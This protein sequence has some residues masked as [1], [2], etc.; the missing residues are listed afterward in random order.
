M[1]LRNLLA[2]A[3]AIAALGACNKKSND[4]PA[5]TA[6]NSTVKITMANPP[7]GGTWNDVVNETSDGYLMGNPNAKVKLVEIGSLGCP[8]C[9]KF[10]DEGVPHVLDLVKTGNLSWEFR[11]YLI[12]GPIDMAAD[13]IARCNGPKTFFPIA[14]AMYK[15]QENWMGKVEAAPEGQL[16]QMQNLPTD[17]IF[18]AYAKLAGLQDWAAARGI[19]Q[20]K[21][22]QCLSNQKMID[23][24]V[25]V[26]SNVNSQYP[27]FHGTPSFILNGSLLPE[28]S[29]WAKLQPQL[30]AALK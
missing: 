3:L 25:Q 30:E 4:T 15:D 14:L 12:H 26:S 8:V 18:K 13:L 2:G 29:S 1:K 11:P 5:A 19:P 6:D 16:Q 22:D 20:A 21:S 27:D 10:D 28:T 17:Q 24:E 23:K 7:P 9:K